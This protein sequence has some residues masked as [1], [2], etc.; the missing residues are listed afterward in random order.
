MKLFDF[1]TIPTLGKALSAYAMRHKT[2]AANIANA[3]TIGYVPKHVNFEE[4]LSSV[5]GDELELRG[6]TTDPRHLALG[7]GDA[8]QARPFVEDDKNPGADPLA[9]G[10]NSV[11]IDQ[12]MADLAKN[13]IRYKFAARL[14]GTAFQEL[15]KSIRGTL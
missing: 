11:D 13:Q 5:S 9:S 2:I 1:T 8:V 6:T 12:E 15:D 7:A 10:A 4:Q 14:T 3:G